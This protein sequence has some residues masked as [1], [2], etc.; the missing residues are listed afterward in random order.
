MWLTV[1]KGAIDLDFWH[2]HPD[3]GGAHLHDLLVASVE[4]HALAHRLASYGGDAEP[5][6]R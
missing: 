1:G 2:S 5:K 3:A 6:I 4:A